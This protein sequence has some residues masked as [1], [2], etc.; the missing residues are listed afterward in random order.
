M[1]LWIHW[2][3]AA[4]RRYTPVTRRVL[5]VEEINS[6]RRPIVPI[7]KHSQLSRLFFAS[8]PSFTNQR[9]VSKVSKVLMKFSPFLLSNLEMRA[10]FTWS[11]CTFSLH[12]CGHTLFTFFDHILRLHTPIILFDHLL[13]S[14]SLIIYS[15]HILPFLLLSIPSASCAVQRAAVNSGPL[16]QSIGRSDVLLCE[17]EFRIENESRSKVNYELNWNQKW[18]KIENELKPNRSWNW[19][20]L[21]Q[22]WDLYSTTVLIQNMMRVCWE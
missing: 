17:S 2:N 8:R 15:I 16:T 19:A 5:L 6:L 10:N 20:T 11:L 4:Y 3:S 21:T 14:Y 12:I 1:N 22:R 18:I 13:Q 7:L 9:L